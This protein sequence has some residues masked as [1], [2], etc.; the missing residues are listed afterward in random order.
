[1]DINDNTK[2][3]ILTPQNIYTV[4]A[5]YNI[6]R[7]LGADLNY[8]F[9]IRL[10]DYIKTYNSNDSNFGRGKT[11][12]HEGGHILSQLLDAVGSYFFHLKGAGP[13]ESLGHEAGNKSGD[14]A[15]QRATNFS[16]HYNGR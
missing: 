10:D 3:V 12:A 2:D 7:T 13:K 6:R 5:D 16:N 11:L 1:M 9:T 15:N 4:Q 8:D 14:E